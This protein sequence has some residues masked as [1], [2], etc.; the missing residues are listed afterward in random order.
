[1]SVNSD[2]TEPIIKRIKSKDIENDSSNALDEKSNTDQNSGHR[3]NVLLTDKKGD[4]MSLSNNDE[5]DNLFPF[6]PDDDITDMLQGVKYQGS[7]P[8]ITERY[9]TAY[10]KLNVQ[11]PADDI[12]I[13]MHSNRICM[14]TLAP[15]HVALRNDVQ[16][17]E[18][19]FKVSNKLDRVLNKVSGKSKHGAQPLQTNSNICIITCSNGKTYTIKCCIIGKLVEVNEA[20]LQNPK[21]LLE[22]PHKGGYLA[23]VLPNIKLL[24]KMKESL[25]TQKEYDLKIF[26][27]QNTTKHL[28]ISEKCTM[29]AS[30]QNDLKTNTKNQ[31]DCD[32]HQISLSTTS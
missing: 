12:C 18:V 26:E 3:E 25:L 30:L 17:T 31:L 13:L 14:L 20:L 15:S 8:T 21:L 22:P 16:I 28:E 19:D 10:Y 24:D 2:D 9:F 23:I 27:R 7:F 32:E 6:P 4:A 11:C 5:D 1:M 29:H